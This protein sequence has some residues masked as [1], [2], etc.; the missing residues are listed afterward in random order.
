MGK[1]GARNRSGPPKDPDSGRSDRLGVR[2][3]ALPPEGHLGPIPTFPLPGRRVTYLSDGVPCVDW[4]ATERV[5]DRELDLWAWA[6]RQPQGAAWSQPSE[7]WR[8]HTIAMWVRTFVVCEGSTA[9]AAD[10]GSL[11]RFADQIGMTPAGLREN[12][13][14]IA[15]EPV[16]EVE[17]MLSEASD[18]AEVPSSSRSRLKV[19]QGGRE[20]S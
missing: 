1:G 9:T 2:F 20:A 14:V 16:A 6:W 18:S 4:E 15:K 5:R 10:K 11:H 3:D 17:E 12:G 19:V 7:A 8:L 13:W